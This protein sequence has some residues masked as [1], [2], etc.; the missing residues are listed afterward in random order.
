MTTT[1]TTTATT[2]TG[3]HLAA[4]AAPFARRVARR[5]H[6]SAGD[7]A[8]RPLLAALPAVTLLRGRGGLQAAAV[9]VHDEGVQVSDEPEATGCVVECDPTTLL[10]VHVVDAA[11][12]DPVRLAAMVTRLLDGPAVPW[13]ERARTFWAQTRDRPGTPASVRLRADDGSQVLLGP[14]TEEP[15]CEVRGSEAALVG[16][17]RGDLPLLVAVLGDVDLSARGSLAALS[18]L[19][20]NGLAYV[21]DDAALPTH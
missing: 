12:A 2:T 13:Q 7:P 20:G 6:E 14:A 5:L 10:D 21:L 3:A 18:V 16:F 17:L 11:G 1:T 15:E 19:Q 4:D 9:A 8:L